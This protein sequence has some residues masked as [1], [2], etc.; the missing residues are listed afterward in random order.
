MKTTKIM[1]ITFLIGSPF[2]TYTMGHDAGKR[3]WEGQADHSKRQKLEQPEAMD[4]DA[5]ASSFVFL[6]ESEITPT[7]IAEIEKIQE[8]INNY[9][10]NNPNKHLSPIYSKPHLAELAW[11]FKR[12][13]KDGYQV[14][15]IRLGLA[16]EKFGVDSQSSLFSP[17]IFYNSIVKG[18][19]D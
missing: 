7:A 8:R 15:V 17:K 1:I 19:S 16:L 9:L 3:K 6:E 2:C 4:L 12:V 10:K 18:I 14:P 5:P 11:L 13:Y